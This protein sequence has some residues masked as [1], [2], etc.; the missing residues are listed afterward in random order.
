MT[1]QAH[2]LLDNEEQV[3]IYN[4][5]L[6][7]VGQFSYCHDELNKLQPSN[8]DIVKALVAVAAVSTS[9]LARGLPMDKTYNPEVMKELFTSTIDAMNSDV[10]IK[11]F[12][13]H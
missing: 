2:K 11:H 8:G 12:I 1:F 5:F 3:Y 6:S 4:Q 10:T 13:P 7:M 9:L